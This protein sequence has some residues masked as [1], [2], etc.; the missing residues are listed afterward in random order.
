MMVAL[1]KTRKRTSH[2]ASAMKLLHILLYL[3]PEDQISASKSEYAVSEIW[4]SV[5]P[6]FLPAAHSVDV[7]DQN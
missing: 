7:L 3:H 1:V 2:Y 4:C 5:L 6:V